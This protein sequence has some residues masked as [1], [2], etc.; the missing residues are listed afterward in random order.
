MEKGKKPFSGFAITGFVLSFFPFLII[1]PILAIIF[2]GI[3]LRQIQKG[4]REGKGLAIA[5]LVM[6]I[7]GVAIYVLFFAAIASSLY[8]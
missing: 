6:G 2:S 3:A 8:Y 7:L 1:P 5:G 4:E